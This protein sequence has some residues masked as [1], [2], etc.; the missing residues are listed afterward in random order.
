MKPQ[1]ILDETL[2]VTWK[3]RNMYEDTCHLW[4]LGFWKTV[5]A[6]PDSQYEMVHIYG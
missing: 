6:R 2:N 1:H 4:N 3:W 5:K